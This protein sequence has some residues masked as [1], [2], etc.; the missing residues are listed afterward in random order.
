MIKRLIDE[1]QSVWEEATAVLDTAEEEKRSLTGEEEEKWDR[2]NEQLDTLDK[3]VETLHETEKRNRRAEEIRSELDAFIRPSDGPTDKP[4]ER[5]EDGLEAEIRKFLRGDTR[6]VDVEPEKAPSMA[7]LRALVK[8]TAN[9]GGNTVPTSFYDQLL[10]HLIEMSA[11]LSAGATVFNTDSGENIDFPKTTGLS[12]ASQTAEA[13]Q[14]AKSNPTFGKLTLGAFKYPVLVDISVELLEDTA[15]DLLGF[16]AQEAGW[17]IGNAFGAKLVTGAG[18]TEPSGIVTGASLGKTGSTGVAGVPSSDDLIDLFYS[19]I[20]PYRARP[21]AAWLMKDSTVGGV[22]KLK[23]TTGQYLWVPSLQAG[24]A[25]TILGKPVFT[26]PNV[27][28]TATS[29]KSVL[30]GDMSRYFV[31]QVRG[32]RFERSDEFQFDTDLVTFKAVIRGDG[33]LADTSGAVK[34]YAGAAT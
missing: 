28:A 12:S 8:G 4:A 3:R 18:T 5:G 21:A 7:E 30:F 11:I 16:I 10:V 24:A 23:D 9:A 32:I 6:S 27:A 13:T 14:I 34:Y 1:R 17:A 22:R 29:A 33:G 19:V 26:D 20:A 2:L 25:D 15:V 31:R